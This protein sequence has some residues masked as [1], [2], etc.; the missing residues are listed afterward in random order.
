MNPVARQ[1]AEHIRTHRRFDG[2]DAGEIGNS[3]AHLV[4]TGGKSLTW[5][6][7]AIDECNRDAGSAAAARRPWSDDV[8]AQK[9]GRYLWKA[10]RPEPS[11]AGEEIHHH[12]PLFVDNGP[13]PTP[14]QTRQFAAEALAKFRAGRKVP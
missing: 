6:K 14:E 1:L 4:E 5:L 8:L 2:I 13:R 7:E 9:L 12:P 3:N 11:D 10:R